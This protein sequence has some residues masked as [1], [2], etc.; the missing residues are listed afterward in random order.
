MNN[1]ETIAELRKWLYGKRTY[2]ANPE[3]LALLEDTTRELQALFASEG[4]HVDMRIEHPEI[5]LGDMFIFIEA[6]HP[7][8]R[9]TERLSGLIGRMKNIE[10]Y[11]LP[12]GKVHLGCRFANVYNVSVSESK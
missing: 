2:T 8:I 3:R 1:R 6:T 12:D 7:I 4:I 9:D 11:S 5:P 10:L